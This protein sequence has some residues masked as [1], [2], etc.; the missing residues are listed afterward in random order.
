MD[1]K[2]YLIEWKRP[3]DS[4]TVTYGDG[5]SC[6]EAVRGQV[7][8]DYWFLAAEDPFV[9]LLAGKE[10]TVG[11]KL[12]LDAASI[13]MILSGGRDD[14][15]RVK[16]ATIR[17]SKV[18]V[19]DGEELAHFEVHLDFARDQSDL[20]TQY[21]MTGDIVVMTGRCWTVSVRIAG[22]VN[23][24][25]LSPADPEIPHM[26]GTGTAEITAQFKYSK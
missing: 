16:E 21:V 24:A 11:D 15:A 12:T 10:L 17:L 23:T 19:V 8:L 1:G 25:G 5:T 13:T 26:K 20:S 2:T 4:V 14:T 7:A 6:H 9:A 3:S 18:E 22:S